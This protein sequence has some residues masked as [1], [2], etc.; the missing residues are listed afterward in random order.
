MRAMNSIAQ[1]LS[2]RALAGIRAALNT[3]QD[4][5]RREVEEVVMYRCPECGELH[6]WES[7][8]KDCCATAP[9]AVEL[10]ACPVCSEHHQTHRDAADCCLWHD[11]DAATRWRIADAVENGSDWLKELGLLGIG[12]SLS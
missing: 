8:A 6:E 10:P 11:L 5:K 7:D 3:P 12:G 2:P 9:G 4:A 1:H